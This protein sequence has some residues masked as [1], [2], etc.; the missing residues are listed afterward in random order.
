MRTL[1]TIVVPQIENGC[2]LFMSPLHYFTILASARENG[3]SGPQQPAQ[4]AVRKTSERPVS[5][6]SF[7]VGRNGGSA[8]AE[9]DP[10]VSNQLRPPQTQ[11]AIE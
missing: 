8:S 10:K 11:Q 3:D 7:D 1:R 5:L 4:Q 2:R 6:R 9:S